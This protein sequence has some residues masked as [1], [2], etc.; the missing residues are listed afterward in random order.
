[1]KESDVRTRSQEFAVRIIM[2]CDN[3]DSRKGR[4]V[5]ISQVVRSATSIGANIFEA[6]YAASRAD[7]IHK[8]QT[9]LK[10]CFET[11]Y[12]LDLMLSAGCIDESVFSSLMQDCGVIRR[13]LVK[14]ITTA[15][16]KQ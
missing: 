16:G 10:E 13:M 6:N 5:L 2:T 3:I 1:M 12:W 15:K 4:G 14:S 11:E 8:L 9:S 7:F